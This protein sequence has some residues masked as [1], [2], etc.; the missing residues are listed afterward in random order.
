MGQATSRAV[1]GVRGIGARANR[2]PTGQVYRWID[3]FQSDR[4]SSVIDRW[5]SFV[6]PDGTPSWCVI[7][8][9]DDVQARDMWDRVHQLVAPPS[10]ST[11][12]GRSE[13]TLGNQLRHPVGRRSTEAHGRGGTPPRVIQSQALWRQSFLAHLQ[14]RDI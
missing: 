10:A 3:P 4:F 12:P 6:T 9:T 1:A 11:T 14:A 8:L 2:F 7:T 13:S 5:A